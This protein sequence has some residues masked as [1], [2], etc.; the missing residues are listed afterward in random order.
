MRRI[1]LF[2][3]TAML[4]GASAEAGPI[5]VGFPPPGGV[6]FSGAGGS[7]SLIQSPGSVRTYSG[8]DTSAWSE[9]YFNLTGGTID[10]ISFSTASTA[11]S[12]VAGSNVIE[13]FP[14]TISAVSDPFGNTV[15]TA[16]KLRTTWTDMFNNPINDFILSA[17]LGTA[18]MPLIVLDIDAADLTT[19]GGGFKV[20]QVYQTTGGVDIK[21]WF[22]S[23]QGRDQCGPLGGDRICS[24]TGGGFWYDPPRDTSAVP[25]PAS[26]VLVGTGL[27]GVLKT[28]RNRRRNQRQHN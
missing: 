24:S 10:G 20:N 15:T 19:W 4:A 1:G 17:P 28:A 9:L 27:L 25:E 23:I 7:G 8:F 14:G 13:W 21:T 22:D 3:M 12:W 26:M 16:V 18:G 5:G 2:V 11:F 6:T